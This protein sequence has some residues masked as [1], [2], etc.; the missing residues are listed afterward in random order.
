MVTTFPQATVS[1]IRMKLT[2]KDSLYQ[3]NPIVVPFRYLI[4]DLKNAHFKL[5]EGNIVSVNWRL[6]GSSVGENALCLAAL[7]KIT[8][9]LVPPF[10]GFLNSD[11]SG[12]RLISTKRSGFTP[13]SH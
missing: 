13:K 11:V 8:H 6:F 5:F 12:T 1:P 4:L 7:V 9:E 3:F 2:V 10:P